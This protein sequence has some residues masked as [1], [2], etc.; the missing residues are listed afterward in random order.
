MS[1]INAIKKHE[2]FNEME[3]RKC[4]ASWEAKLRVYTEHQL[5]YVT[6][7]AYE[8]TEEPFLT[9]VGPWKSMNRN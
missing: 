2:N 3:R 5:G 7:V 4:C 8:N 9:T 6:S 1:L